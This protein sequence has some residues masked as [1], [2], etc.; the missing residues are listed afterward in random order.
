MGGNV[1]IDFT[2]FHHAN[3]LRLLICYRP[4]GH[5][6]EKKTVEFASVAICVR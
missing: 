3:H 1:I 2:A 6:D 4:T 5:F